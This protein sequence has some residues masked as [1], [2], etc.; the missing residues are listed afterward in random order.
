VSTLYRVGG[1]A[2]TRFVVAV[3][4]LVWLATSEG[5]C[6][7]SEIA[8]QVQAHAT[9]LRRIMSPLVQA[10]IVASREGR[11]GGYALARPADR[12]TLGEVYVVVRAAS[13]DAG[14]EGGESSC[15]PQAELLDA[16]LKDILEQAEE[17]VVEFLNRITI[18]DLVAR[19]TRLRQNATQGSTCG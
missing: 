3:Q 11:V 8:S 15:G 9:F 5:V 10:G 13:A 4:S 2:P 6:P 18:A 17:R 16:V 12:I 7:S 1:I 14:E 19:V